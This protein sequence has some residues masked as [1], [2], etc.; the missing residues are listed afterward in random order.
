MLTAHELFGFMSPALADEILESTYA[1]NR[2]LYRAALGAVAQAMRV[3]PIF[4][5]R[6]PRKDRHKSMAAALSR[7]SME[8]ATSG[9]LRGWLVH[10]QSAV[11]VDFLNALGIPH[12]EGVVEELPPAME[13]SRLAAALD[14]LLTKHPQEVVV[15]YLHAFNSMNGPGWKNLQATLENDPRLQFTH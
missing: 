13:D 15:V 3:R 11:L 4:L 10:H 5:E 8:E 7:P 9:L 12:K 6:Q 1:D 14:A 2:D